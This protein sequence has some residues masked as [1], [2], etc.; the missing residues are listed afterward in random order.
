MNTARRPIA[1]TYRTKQAS[2]RI[3]RACMQN[4]SMFL[5]GR[6]SYEDWR[7]RQEELESRLTPAPELPLVEWDPET[8]EAA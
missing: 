8:P 5:E 7:N 6:I 1:E 2:R 3:H 4:L